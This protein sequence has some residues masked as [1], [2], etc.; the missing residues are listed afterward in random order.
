MRH[1]KACPV[2]CHAD[3]PHCFKFLIH[4]HSLTHKVP[5]EYEGVSDEESVVLNHLMVVGTPS[6]KPELD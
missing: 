5:F 6:K 4:F 3:A 1:A 2:C